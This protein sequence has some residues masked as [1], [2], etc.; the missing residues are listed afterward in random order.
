[1]ARFP[2]LLALPP[3]AF[4]ALAGLFAAGMLRDDP[5]ALPSARAGQLAPP[6]VLGALPGKTVVMDA[7]LRGAGVKLVNFW[8]SWCAPCRVEHP[9][10]MD[11]AGQGVAIYGVNYKDQ[12]ADAIGFLADLGDPFLAVGTDREGRTG[13]DWGLYGVP[14]TFVLDGEGRVILRYAGPITRR[15]LD[16]TIRPAL[17]QALAGGYH[18]NGPKD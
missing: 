8:A 14:E 3:I 16:D 4:A 11:L 7:D 2:Y 13:I 12:P 10:L 5:E 15:V 6:V 1:M 18:T 9:V 17:A